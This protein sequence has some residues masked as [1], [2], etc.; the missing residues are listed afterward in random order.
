MSSY[1]LL[2]QPTDK[3]VNSRRFKKLSSELAQQTYLQNLFFK[4]LTE[5]AAGN[6][7]VAILL[8][9]RSY[10]EFSQDRLIFPATIHFDP[11]FL[12]QLTTEELFTLAA[13]LQHDIINAQHHALIF[14]QDIQ[15]SLLLL[16]RMANKGFLVQKSN[17]YQIHPLLYRPV[18]SILKSGNIIH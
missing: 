8:W 18:V 15:H 17:G 4:Q 9:L 12:Y 2:F 11:T 3:I 7:T 16:N 6:I 10:V 13:V 1:Q 14:H 5:L